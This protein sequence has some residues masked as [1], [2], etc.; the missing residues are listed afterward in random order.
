[1]PETDAEREARMGRAVAFYDIAR[2]EEVTA[3]SRRRAAR[4]RAETLSDRALRATFGPP[5]SAPDI[6]HPAVEEKPDEPD[7]D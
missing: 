5:E 1:M 4:L 7:L 2:A 6:N 3:A